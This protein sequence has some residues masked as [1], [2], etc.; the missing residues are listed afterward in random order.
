VL[1]AA[2]QAYRVNT[3]TA[4]DGAVQWNFTETTTPPHNTEFE[5]TFQITSGASPV[6][7]TI[8][9]YFETQAANPATALTFIL[10]FDTGVGAA[11]LDRSIEL[12][13]QCSGVGAC[14]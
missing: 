6:I 14:P 10:Y 12:T 7:T 2:G 3:A 9:V 8:T 4:G 5:I 11:V 13:Q 1:P